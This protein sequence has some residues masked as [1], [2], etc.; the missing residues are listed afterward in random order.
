[1]A[2]KDARRSLVGS[3]VP[4]SILVQM[5]EHPG[6]ISGY[7][8]D[9]VAAFD[10]DLP[11][12]VVAAVRFVRDR[13]LN[14]P[15]DPIHIANGRVHR[16]TFDRIEEIEQALVTVKGMSRAKVIAGLI[17]LKLDHKGRRESQ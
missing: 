16:E 5:Q 6:S 1:M 10:G 12:L 17:Q 4:K 13:K 7:Y 14:A 11:A 15:T 3:T 9:A 2:F 8:E